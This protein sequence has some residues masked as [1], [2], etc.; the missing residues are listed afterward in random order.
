LRYENLALYGI[1]F[2]LILQGKFY[3]PD[4]CVDLLLQFLYGFFCVLGKFSPFIKTLAQELPASLHIMKKTFGLPFGFRKL[5]V[6]RKCLSIYKYKDCLDKA[7]A[8]PASKKCTNVMYPHHPMPNKRVSCETPLL[9]SVE[10]ASGHAILYPHLVYCYKDFKSC[11]QNL[12]LSSA[13]V[14]N[15]QLWRENETNT[16]L[17]S[18]YNGNIWKDFFLVN[19][20]PLINYSFSKNKYSFGY[21]LNVDWFQPYTHTT[22]S[23]GVIY[24]TVLNLPRFLR[25]KRENII[26][27]GII[28]GP[29]EPKLNIN[30]FLK[31][32]V[33]EFQDFWTGVD[34]T[35]CTDGQNRTEIVKAAILC[36]TCDMP[37]GRKV[38][39]FL[40]HSATLGCSKYLKEF[41]GAAGNK[42][43]SGFDTSEWPKRTN[44]GHRDSIFKI[45]KCKTKTK[46]KE[47]AKYGCRN[48]CLLELPYF[49]APRM[50]CVDPMHNLFLG[51]GKH[52]ITIWEDQ[53]Y[54]RRR[55]FDSIQE[56]IDSIAI[57]LK[58]ASGFS[59]FKAV[60]FKNWI[61]IYSIP[62]LFKI[63][64]PE[65]LEC[66]R[67]FVLACRIL[68]K[69]SLS[70]ADI[71]LA[72]H[73]YAFV[74]K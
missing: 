59:G 37:A 3:L 63:L 74:P 38:C 45:K 51:T 66:W 15:C 48:S 60:Q 25:Y 22:F 41:P 14:C 20:S 18:I 5:I 69:Q 35:V 2:I 67:H 24:L 28:P 62:V 12:L 73:F 54:L 23:V 32:L 55:E 9:K 43:Y 49:D 7:S 33:D 16:N 47:E 61:T 72:H 26:L 46:Q 65:H 19:K 70:K 64:P 71:E 39:G 44:E 40:G 8:I 36:V 29:H 4:R 50:L 68:C 1:R 27:I 17:N 11:L 58:I 10:F 34:L 13:F 52:M 30:S 42:D 21:A 57:L 56:F 31:P 53:D 6:C